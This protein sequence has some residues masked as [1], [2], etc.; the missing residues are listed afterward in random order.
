MFEGD[1]STPST[2]T[3]EFVNRDATPRITG[4]FAFAGQSDG[5]A[6]RLPGDAG[7]CVIYGKDELPAAV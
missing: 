6:L 5:E 4:F 3:F 2:V 7:F 1:G